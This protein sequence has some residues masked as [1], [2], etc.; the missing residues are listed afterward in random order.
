MWWNR[1]IEAAESESCEFVFYSKYEKEPV[2]FKQERS[3]MVT[4]NCVA[5]PCLLSVA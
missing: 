3:D 1:A 4:N 2:K 5:L